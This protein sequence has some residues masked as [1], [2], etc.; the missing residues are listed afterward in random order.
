MANTSV[1]VVG[2]AYSVFT[3]ARQNASAPSWT[4]YNYILKGNTSSDFF[5]FYGNNPGKH[6]ATF[7]GTSA[8]W[9]DLNSN[10]P[11]ISVTSTTLVTGMVISGSV[12]TPYYSGIAMSTKTGTTGNFSGIALADAYIVG[13][14]FTGQNWN[15]LIYEVIIIPTAVT[16]FERQQIEGYLAHK[17]GVQAT[18]PASHPYRLIRP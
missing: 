1:P 7:T 17:W 8:G 11:P 3:V 5:I 4:D 6:F 15:G 12:M 2:A 9:N 13:Q 10:S 18:L 16:T 14:N